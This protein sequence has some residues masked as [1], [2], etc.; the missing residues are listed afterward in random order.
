MQLAGR[1]SAD[2]PELAV[3]LLG[4]RLRAALL[5]DDA[6]GRD[7]RVV[8]D[9]AAVGVVCG[10]IADVGVVGQAAAVVQCFLC[11]GHQRGMNCLLYGDCSVHG[12]HQW[13]PRCSALSPY[14]RLH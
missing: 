10:A 5:V 13:L 11:A 3:G 6:P 12:G 9:A 4:G 2:V 8:L 14:A 7:V 1:T